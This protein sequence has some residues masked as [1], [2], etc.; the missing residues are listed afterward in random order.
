MATGTP[1]GS[2]ISLTATGISGAAVTL[3]IPASAAATFHYITWV[4]ITLFRVTVLT[5]GATASI[6]TS[7]NLNGNPSFDISNAA[8]VLGGIERMQIAPD[9]PIK[10]AVAAT[11]TTFV[12]PIVTGGIWRVSALWFVGP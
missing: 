8:G 2:T 6:V 4:E 5:P 1:I 11:A 3:T 12:T 9:I 10:S 7:T